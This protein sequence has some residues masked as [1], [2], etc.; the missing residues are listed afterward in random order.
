MGTIREW[1]RRRRERRSRL[2]GATEP[3]P[4]C[5]QWADAGQFAARWNA[6]SPE[7]RDQIVEGLRDTENQV[8]RWRD[9]SA[10]WERCVRDVLDLLDVLDQDLQ[11]ALERQAPHEVREG[12][13]ITQ[14]HLRRAQAMITSGTQALD[15][16][17]AATAEMRVWLFEQQQRASQAA[18]EQRG[19]A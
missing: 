3:G 15:D 2:Q 1:L 12:A 7:R 6:V 14:A 13:A 16:P 17:L 5:S 19:R 8:A 9:S 4:E 11:W 10:L 18:Y